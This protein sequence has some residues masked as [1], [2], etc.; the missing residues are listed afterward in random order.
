M[1]QEKRIRIVF[2]S[3]TF[4]NHI[5]L[6]EL[7]NARDKTRSGERSTL[8]VIIDCTLNPVNFRLKDPPRRRD[9][10]TPLPQR[11]ASSL[12]LMILE[13]ITMYDL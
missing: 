13:G 7:S 3:G 1:R 4:M 12:S 2:K 10:R 8:T 11:K 9:R 5:V 6:S